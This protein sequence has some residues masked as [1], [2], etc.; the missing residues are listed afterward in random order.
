MQAKPDNVRTR[1]SRRAFLAANGALAAGMYLARP[2]I[3]RTAETLA[4]NGGNKAVTASASGATSWPRYGEEERKAVDAVVKAL[5]AEGVSIRN[6]GYTVSHRDVVYREPQWWHHPPVIPDRL[7]GL[8][9]AERTGIS[10]PRFTKPVPELIDQYV[11]AFEK[12]WAHRAEL[13]RA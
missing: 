1:S 7:A 6:F 8:E 10:L 5:K 3:A 11:K 2:S 4:V 9:E 13:G 12:V